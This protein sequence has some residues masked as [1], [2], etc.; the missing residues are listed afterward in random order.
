MGKTYK[1]TVFA[2]VQICKRNQ[3]R[4]RCKTRPNH[5]LCWTDRVSNRTSCLFLG[6]GKNGKQ[7]NHLRENFPP[8]DPMAKDGI[9]DIL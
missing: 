8:A 1:N 6:F 4:Y 2:Y 7:C 5:W 3:I 9:T